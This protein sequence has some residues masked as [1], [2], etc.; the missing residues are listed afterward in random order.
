MPTTKSEMRCSFCGRLLGMTHQSA[1][2]R[3]SPVTT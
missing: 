2:E 1:W 3:F